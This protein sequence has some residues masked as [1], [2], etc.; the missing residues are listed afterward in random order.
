[1]TAVNQSQPTAQGDLARTPFAHLVLYLHRETLSGTLIVDRGGFET[2]VLFRN[3]RAVAARPIPR[4]AGLQE[5][6]LELC[7]LSEGGYSFSE[8]D[9]VG[10]GSGVIRGT[11]DPFTFIT[12]ALR[13]HIRD[14]VVTSVVDRY[15]S[16]RLRLTAD[17]DL[18][19]LGLRGIEAR[20]AESLRHHPR[21]VEEFIQRSELVPVEARK[22]VYLLLITKHAF[23][24]GSEGPGISGIRAAVD[25]TLSQSSGSRSRS[26]SA[27]PAGASGQPPQATASGRPSAPGAATPRSPSQPSIPSPRTP[28]QPSVSSP[29][30]SSQPSVPVT[31]P[32][33]KPGQS[34]PP[35]AGG[36]LPAWQQLAS[37]RATPGRSSAPPQIPTPSM[38]PPPIEALDDLGKLRRAEQLV[39]RRNFTEA[40][41]IVDDLIVRD[42]QNAEFHALRA[43]ILYMQFSGERPPRA[44]IDA[45]ERALRLNEEQPRALYVKGLVLKRMNRPADALRYFQR[46]LDVDPHHLDAQRELR[47]ARMRRD[48]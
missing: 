4:G 3:G 13:G 16:V 40:E 11:V 5:G 6:L 47:L 12:E 8:E 24:E 34:P 30:S 41:R 35:P 36:S 25:G 28:S 19:R 18:K 2:K 27:P 32:S 42:G 31:R 17:A 20:V 7:A 46:A 33:T 21:V 22:L 14:A 43:L 39:E 23:P 10:E 38:A 9:L 44:L 37:L 29:R 48:K 26:P 45:I 15:Q 1:M